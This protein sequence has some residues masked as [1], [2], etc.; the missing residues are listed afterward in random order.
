MRA[1]KTE[2]GRLAAVVAG[3]AGLLAAMHKSYEKEWDRMGDED[4]KRRGF[5]VHGEVDEAAREA[6][7]A[8]QSIMYKSLNEAMRLAALDAELCGVGALYKGQRI[9]IRDLQVVRFDPTH[10]GA[11]TAEQIVSA[12]RRRGAAPTRIDEWADSLEGDDGVNVSHGAVVQQ[13][14]SLARQ[15]RHDDELIGLTDELFEL[16][17]PW[18]HL[19][20]LPL[21]EALRSAF[22]E[23]VE[24]TDRLRRERDHAREKLAMRIAELA[25]L[26]HRIKVLEDANYPLLAAKAIGGVSGRRLEALADDLA[27]C[28]AGNLIVVKNAIDALRAEAAW[29][30][31]GTAAEIEEPAAGLAAEVI[32]AAAEARER[33]EE[34]LRCA[35]CGWAYPIAT[36]DVDDLCSNCDS[37]E[38]R[39][40]VEV[41]EAPAGYVW[42]D[43]VPSTGDGAGDAL[44]AARGRLKAFAD[45]HGPV[46]VSPPTEPQQSEAAGALSREALTYIVFDP[47]GVFV[48]VENE[49]GESV[50]PDQTGAGFD[51]HPRSMPD[52]PASKFRRLGPFVT[53]PALA[54]AE[55]RLRAAE[56]AHDAVREGLE[57]RK[58]MH[59]ETRTHL[60]ALR[61]AVIALGEQAIHA[62]LNFAETSGYSGAAPVRRAWED[63]LA[64]AEDDDTAG[65]PA[66]AHVVIEGQAER[67][68]SLEDDLHMERDATVRLTERARRVARHADQRIAL[69]AQI[70]AEQMERVAGDLESAPRAAERVREAMEAADA[71][72]A[73]LRQLADDFRRA[74]AE[75]G[76]VDAET[77][78]DVRERMDHELREAGMDATTPGVRDIM[79]AVEIEMARLHKAVDDLPQVGE[80]WRFNGE[81]WTITRVDEVRG[82]V[83]VLL[84]R[85]EGSVASLMPV[86]VAD[87]REHGVKVADAN[88]EEVRTEREE[89]AAKIL[90][91]FDPKGTNAELRRMMKEFAEGQYRGGPLVAA[92][93]R[94]ERLEQEV[95]N[96]AAGPGGYEPMIQPGTRWALPGGRR[97]VVVSEASRSGSH[98][99]AVD[100]DTGDVGEVTSERLAEA[101][102]SGY[103]DDFEI[104]PGQRWYITGPT[105]MS[106]YVTI[107]GPRRGFLWPTEDGAVSDRILRDGGAIC[108]GAVSATKPP[109]SM[110]PFLPTHN[111]TEQ[112]PC[113]QWCA[114]RQWEA[115]VAAYGSPYDAL[116]AAPA[117]CGAGEAADDLYAAL[118]A[119][120]G[121]LE[122]DERD[123]HDGDDERRGE[124]ADASP[125]RARA[126]VGGGEDLRDKAQAFVDGLRSSLEG[127][128]ALFGRHAAWRAMLDDLEGVLDDLDEA[129]VQEAWLWEAVPEPLR[130]RLIEALARS[131]PAKATRGGL[132]AEMAGLRFARPTPDEVFDLFVNEAMTP[133]LAELAKGKLRGLGYRGSVK[134]D[135]EAAR[136]V[137]VP[138]GDENERGRLVS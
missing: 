59:E 17:K 45:A 85:E 79:G 94:I 37:G 131:A 90:A 74:A 25:I 112:E 96:L 66:V 58:E 14:R 57:I 71:A 114:V 111:H 30:R 62:T 15:L 73:D 42:G 2:H 26:G 77:L 78:I 137:Y 116:R 81:E 19:G 53:L 39:V 32:Q 105:A 1:L 86:P 119:L 7:R 31:S 122:V 56:E 48:E 89:T 28:P 135:E 87:L 76:E 108:L 27:G 52:M 92:A 20:D 35:V 5:E 130:A 55:R 47:A 40:A 138:S 24:Y 75:G 23:H 107:A 95:Q 67:I 60:L 18:N 84:S 99:A 118:T 44:D 126:Q 69:Q 61:T 13:M 68:R 21:T 80:S 83:K 10:G 98:W 64:L 125:A 101:R 3:F 136:L 11:I 51:D 110:V 29:M 115:H 38:L 4:S 128:P 22:A 36:T 132:E 70:V 91:A 127:Q 124:A 12:R 104:A 33:G 65:P 82:V 134:L 109:L 123:G 41:K 121:K 129:A 9:D 8:T 102:F 133:Q 120:G 49:R 100:V 43:E 103:S 117:T 16:L 113:G 63:L 93:E 106:R 88:V 34:Y 46:S 72:A 50:S 6:I 54:E 97:V